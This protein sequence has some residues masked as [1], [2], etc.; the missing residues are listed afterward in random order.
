MKWKKTNLHQLTNYYFELYLK[1][2]K[3]KYYTRG[4]GI[5]LNEMR[6]QTIWNYIYVISNILNEAKH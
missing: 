4:K 2:R 3:T 1:M 5:Q 6:N